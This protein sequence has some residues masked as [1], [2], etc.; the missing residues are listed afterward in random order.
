MFELLE[1]HANPCLL[2]KYVTDRKV[3][4]WAGGW[5]TEWIGGWRDEG[6]GG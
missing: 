3:G 2:N 5:M 1:V 6:V 4:G